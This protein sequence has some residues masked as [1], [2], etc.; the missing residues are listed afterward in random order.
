MRILKLDESCISNPKSEILNWT[1]SSSRPTSNWKFRISDL[2]CRIRPISKFL[3]LFVLTST[4]AYSQ[5][6]QNPQINVLK[7]Q[8]N[9]YML[10]GAVGNIAVQISN[11]GVLLV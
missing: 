5:Q 10:V 2:R 4:A 7:V 6:N 3:L 9:V 1:A 8:G 11:D